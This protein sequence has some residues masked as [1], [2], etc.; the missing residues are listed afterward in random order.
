MPPAQALFSH[1]PGKTGTWPLLKD[2]L[3]TVA[4]TAANLTESCGLHKMAWVAGLFHD[5]GKAREEFQQYLT[6]QHEGRPCSSTPHS[7]WGALLAWRLL[8]GQLGLEVALIVAGHHSGLEEKGTLTA[9]LQA[10]SE[11]HPGVLDSVREFLFSLLQ[12]TPGPKVSAPPMEDL[13]REARLRFLLSAVVDA[14]RLHTQVHFDPDL[15][16]Q[17]KGFPELPLLWENFARHQERLLKE[18]APTLV[19]RIRG[20]V[21]E[22]CLQAAGH[23]PGLFRLTVPTGGGKTLSGLGFALRH[24][25]LHG[26]RRVVAALPYT[27]ITDQTAKVYRTVLG[28][29]AVLEHHSQVDFQGKSEE[30]ESQTPLAVRMRLATE[31]WDAPIIVTTTVQLLESLFARHPSRCR[32]LHHLA[33]S[34]I[35][36][37]EVQTL[38]PGLLKPTADML[39]TL[40]EDYGVTLVLSTATQPALESPYY[41]QEFRGE[42]REIVPQF[43]SHFDLLKR[44]RYERPPGALSLADVAKELTG[45]PQVLAILNTRREALDLFGYLADDPFTYHLSTLLCGAHRRRILEEVRHRLREGQPVRLI[46]TQVVEAGVD[47]DFPVVY[48]AMGPLDRIVQAAGRCNREGRWAAGRVVIVEVEGGKAPQG[49][50]A[51]GLEKAK[52][53]LELH[54]TASLHDPDFYR[55]YFQGLFHDLDL[56]EENIQK[57]R[58]DFNFPE[59]ARR[60]RLIKEATGPVAVPY[61]EGPAWLAKWSASPSRT[62]WRRL[63]P[64]LVNL[65]EREI[66]QFLQEGWL[67]EVTPG[68]YRWRGRYDDRKGLVGPLHDPCDLVV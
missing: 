58:G 54:P 40:V 60:Y 46:S 1:T 22:A 4:Q 3:L 14:D 12:E 37:D 6:A 44:V 5:L 53:L 13:K 26:K 29:E 35:I 56:D 50:Y 67:E 49:P 33:H 55:E 47:L 2:H 57:L 15:A 21:Y 64:Y 20:E 27:S 23:A 9:R 24:A 17:R 32:K 51:R 68:L 8:P 39:C 11:K 66:R 65:Y 63:Q 7:P 30:E 42:V 18:A 31:N 34:V 45:H 10:L 28:E 59:V 25:L 19:N 62:I 38:P 41:L 16:A 36:L 52:K 43:K 61:G 48:R